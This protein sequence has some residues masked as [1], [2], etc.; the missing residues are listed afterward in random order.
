MLHVTSENVDQLK[1]HDLISHSSHDRPP[2]FIRKGDKCSAGEVSLFIL[3]PGLIIVTQTYPEP[4]KSIPQ[5][6]TL[7][8]SKIYFNT[9]SGNQVLVLY[10]KLS[11]EMKIFT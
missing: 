1:R 9:S 11:A 6:N 4:I 8:F 7:F 5:P 3:N 2:W 10:F